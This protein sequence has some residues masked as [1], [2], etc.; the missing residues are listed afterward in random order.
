MWFKP[1]PT[2]YEPPNRPTT[3]N[4]ELRLYKDE[5]SLSVWRMGL[6]TEDFLRANPRHEYPPAPKHK[7][8]SDTVF[9]RTTAGAV[10]DL[11]NGKGQPL[12]LDVVPDDDDRTRPGHAGLLDPDRPGEQFSKST[13]KALRV[14]FCDPWSPPTGLPTA[15]EVPGDNGGPLGR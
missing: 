11:K 7:L 9:L 4:F 14:L 2:F 8:P 1:H 5:P 10:R 6:T 3:R 15:A 12:G 13:R